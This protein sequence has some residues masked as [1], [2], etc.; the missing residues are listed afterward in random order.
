MRHVIVGFM[1]LAF[2]L[3]SFLTLALSNMYIAIY[4]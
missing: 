4:H 1:T 2:E 3:L